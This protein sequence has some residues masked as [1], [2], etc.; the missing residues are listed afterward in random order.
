M[1]A[2]CSNKKYDNSET[3]KNGQAIAQHILKT[4]YIANE[5]INFDFLQRQELAE[6]LEGEKISST[7]KSLNLVK[8]YNTKL[9][10]FAAYEKILVRLS[11]NH[12]NKLLKQDFSSLLQDINNLDNKKF[13]RQCSDIKKILNSSAH[14]YNQIIYKISLLLY[15][16]YQ[17]DVFSWIQKLDSSY[18]Y[19]SATIDRIPTN[20]FDKDKLEKFIYEP[21]KGKN[22]LIKI[23]K[24][25]LKQEAYEKKSRFNDKTTNLLDIFNS[26]ISILQE[27]TKK[28]KD[29]DYI[30]FTNNKISNTLKSYNINDEN[31]K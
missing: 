27:N 15:N 28:D 10:I 12:Q 31:I 22:N 24:L 11:D 8:K 7:K 14:N 9:N 4:Y 29:L 13:S 2:A 16:L 20:V 18:N 1:F 25:K 30:Y 21:Y 26:Y 5:K 3:F 6:L 23:Y 19:Y 17:N